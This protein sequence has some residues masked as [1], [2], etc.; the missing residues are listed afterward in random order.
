MA[1]D[2]HGSRLRALER[3]FVSS[4]PTVAII[5]AW[6]TAEEIAAA[7]R[8]IADARARG[9]DTVVVRIAFE[10]KHRQSSSLSQISSST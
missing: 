8:A 2:A 4:G 5:T 6:M 10:E 3:Q 7:E 1:F 9:K